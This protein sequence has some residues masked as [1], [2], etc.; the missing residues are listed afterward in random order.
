MS[1][2]IAS[3]RLSEKW[4]HI[5]IIY[6]GILLSTSNS[7]MVSK[8]NPS[9]IQ[10]W[11]FHMVFSSLKVRA[12]CRRQKFKKGKSRQWAY[13]CGVKWFTVWPLALQLWAGRQIDRQQL[14]HIFKIKTQYNTYCL[15]H[16]VRCNWVL[17]SH[18]Q[19]TFFPFV[20]GT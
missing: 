11:N 1:W 2:C 9:R 17:V 16:I 13:Q 14:Y 12:K 6:R 7:I 5:L 18:G 8:C 20:L 4:W 10:K 19:T 3:V 15:Y